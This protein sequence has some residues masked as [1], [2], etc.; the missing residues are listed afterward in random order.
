VK[1]PKAYINPKMLRWGRETAGYTVEEAAKKIGRVTVTPDTIRDWES[2][3]QRPSYPQFEKLADFY[4]RPTIVFYGKKPRN[5]QR[6]DTDFRSVPSQYLAQTPPSV[7]F[8]IRA[9][10][11]RQWDL[12]EL[13]NGALPAQPDAFL[14][15]IRRKGGDVAKIAAAVRKQLKVS[16]D[17]QKG[18][19]NPNEA[20]K[21]WREAVESLGVWVFKEPFKERGGEYDGFYLP[22]KYFPVIVL[23]SGKSPRRQIFTLFHE[24]GHFLQ[25]E[26]GICFRHDMEQELQG[27]YRE[28]EIF[29]NAFAAEFLVSE[30]DLSNRRRM[31]NDGEIEQYADEYKVSREVI[32]RKCKDAGLISWQQY[33]DTVNRWRNAAPEP[34]SGARGGPPYYVKKMNYLGDKFLKL[35]FSQYDEYR[36]TDIQ[37]MQYF[38]VGEEV[39]F[40]LEA[41]VYRR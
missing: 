20:F 9:A 23:N 31:L 39:L 15:T 33:A 38:D 12:E 29:C 28:K 2:G 36:V 1:I 5:K 8:A 16:F 17:E 32:L 6:I 18:W 27:K 24:L 19:K 21:K 10:T 3:K 30:L 25:R 13:H 37:L 14:K 35:A 7:R 22:H 40:Q 41:A 4:R 11:V 34:R 26:G